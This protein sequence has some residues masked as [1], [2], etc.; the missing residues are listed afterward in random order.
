MTLLEC[1]HI[2]IKKRTS[3]AIEPEFWA[4]V[5]LQAKAEGATW[6][7]WAAAAL[8]QGVGGGRASRLRVAILAAARG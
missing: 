5:E 6:Q 2:N 3:I 8:G 4:A 1:R 7:E